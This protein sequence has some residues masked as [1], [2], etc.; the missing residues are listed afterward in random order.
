MELDDTINRVKQLIEQRA[1]ID[2][3]LAGIFG[4]QA[5]QKRT[6]TCSKCG[7]PGHTARSCTKEAAQ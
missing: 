3:E 1:A 5:P 4:G 2:A 7:E 6:V